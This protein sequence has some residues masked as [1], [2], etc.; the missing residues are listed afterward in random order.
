[1]HPQFESIFKILF[2]LNCW[3][4]IF[5]NN[6]TCH[7]NVLLHM[8]ELR[9]AII[10]VLYLS[11]ILHK[12]VTNCYFYLMSQN[13]MKF[14]PVVGTIE[15]MKILNISA[16]YVKPFLRWLS[17]ISM[18]RCEYFKNQLLIKSD[19]WYIRSSPAVGFRK[20]KQKCSNF[21]IFCHFG[22]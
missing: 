18:F 1:M 8:G 21:Y 4:V 22:F 10:F 13:S 20:S 12:A 16:F 2:S 5:L 3:F 17:K 15:K 6:Q 9:K 14:T 19:N 11:V 7:Q